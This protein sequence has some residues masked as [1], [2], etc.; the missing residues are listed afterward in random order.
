MAIAFHGNRTPAFDKACRVPYNYL[1]QHEAGANDGA[2]RGSWMRKW[3]D[4]SWT[5]T[6]LADGGALWAPTV[7]GTAQGQ[8]RLYNALHPSGAGK[9][10]VHDT[11]VT[12]AVGLLPYLPTPPRPSPLLPARPPA[13]PP[14]SASLPTFSSSL[15]LAVAS[16]AATVGAAAAAPL[17]AAV[18]LT[19]PRIHTSVC[20]RVWPHRA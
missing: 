9:L 13:R 12:E 18:W 14:S 19:K 8:T 2:K 10:G 4:W 20:A 16:A 6:H 7:G 1:W 15:V 5:N 3:K 11:S 17:V